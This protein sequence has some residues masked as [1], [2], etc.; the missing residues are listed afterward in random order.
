MISGTAVSRTIYTCAHTAKRHGA[1]ERNRVFLMGHSFGALLLERTFMNA[2][3]G[4]LTKEWAWGETSS[5][6]NANPLPFDTV[7]L[8]N[9]AAPSIYAKQF[10][11]YLAA[12]RQ[13]MVR[14]GVPGAD[15]PIF[16]SLT[17]EADGATGKIHRLGNLFA[18]GSPT[19]KHDYYG[20]EDF[21]LKKNPRKLEPRVPQAEYYRMTPGHNPLLV[22]R[23]VEP[24]PD[25]H[26]PVAPGLC[27]Q[28]N[29][30]LD[31]SKERALHF[32]TT[33]DDRKS[34]SQWMIRRA[35][36]LS[37]ENEK[38]STWGD[39][40]Q[41]VCWDT[42]TGPTREDRGQSAYWI[43]R[44]PGEIINGHND[45]WNQKAMETYAALFRV[46]TVMKKHR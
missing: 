14:A 44:C 22:N 10:Q 12:H 7:L 6:T 32:F 40:Y 13:A 23:W 45:I 33:N 34:V 11:G 21:I 30:K 31:V 24:C 16:I 41:P 19:L 28:E 1:K 29:L 15:A 43:M 3:L 39:G 9:S 35:P 4:E 20:Y 42:G 8:V 17:S 26:H 37:L 38:W 18:G 2:T 27:L 5:N 36:E 25:P 46:A